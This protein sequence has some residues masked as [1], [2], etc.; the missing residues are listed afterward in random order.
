MAAEAF[1]DA[2]RHILQSG[3]EFMLADQRDRDLVW[4]WDGLRWRGERLGPVDDFLDARPPA[5]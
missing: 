4:L 5:G 2:V 1:R 3:D